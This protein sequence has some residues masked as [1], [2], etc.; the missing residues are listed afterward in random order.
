MYKATRG[1]KARKLIKCATGN[2]GINQKIFK[3][4]ENWEDRDAR[5]YFYRTVQKWN[6]RTRTNNNIPKG[7]EYLKLVLFA[8]K[9]AKRH[10]AIIEA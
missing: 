5:S 10:A 6:R 9:V 2:E 7:W 1:R 3:K 8:K 4:H